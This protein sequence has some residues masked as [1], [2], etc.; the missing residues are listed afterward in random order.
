MPETIERMSTSCEP[1]TSPTL[2]A[3]ITVGLASA[4]IAFTSTGACGGRRRRLVAAPDET[5]TGRQGQACR[6]DESQL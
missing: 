3:Y 2:S 6:E 4:V 5:G 1:F